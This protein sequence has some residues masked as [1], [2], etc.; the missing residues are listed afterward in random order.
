MQLTIKVQEDMRSQERAAKNDDR[1]SWFTAY[2]K[3]ITGVMYF[4]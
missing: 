1:A 3:L 2:I 4:K